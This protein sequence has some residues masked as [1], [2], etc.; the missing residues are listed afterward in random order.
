MAIAAIDFI[1]ALV[2]M[3]AG[4]AFLLALGAV[5]YLWERRKK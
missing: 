3:L 5:A 4:L 2:G 1:G